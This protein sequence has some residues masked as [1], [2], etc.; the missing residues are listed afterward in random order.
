M[1]LTDEELCATYDILYDEYYFGRE[2]M[3][4]FTEEAGGVR[5]VL[6][7]IEAEFKRRKL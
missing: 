4:Q 2:L 3:Y 6:A 7:K 5:S 1:E